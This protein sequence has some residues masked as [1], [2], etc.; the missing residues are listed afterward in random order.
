MMSLTYLVSSLIGA[1]ELRVFSTLLGLFCRWASSFS[2]REVVAKC[3]VEI[4]EVLDLI[5]NEKRRV[6][7]KSD[8]GLQRWF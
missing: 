6:N 2:P 7:E 3:K 8:M 4:L 1:S 5:E